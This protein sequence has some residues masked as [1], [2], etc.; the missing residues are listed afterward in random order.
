MCRH[1]FPRPF[2]LSVPRPPYFLSLSSL[3]SLY[4]PPLSLTALKSLP[5]ENV[6]GGGYLRSRRDKQNNSKGSIAK[7]NRQ[8]SHGER[9]WGGEIVNGN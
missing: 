4:L 7:A 5:I 2:S 6:D 1:D 8:A 9:G 3:F